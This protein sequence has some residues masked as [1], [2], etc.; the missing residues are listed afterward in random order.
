[1]ATASSGTASPAMRPFPPARRS[2][3]C[4]AIWSGTAP[5]RA[6]AGRGTAS[7]PACRRSYRRARRI[8]TIAIDRC[9]VVRR[10][11]RGDSAL[12]AD[13][14]R[15]LRHALLLEDLPHLLGRDGDVDVLHPEGREPVH[16]RIAL[17]RG[18]AH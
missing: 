10:E 6:T 1:M 9:T 4:S 15:L 5:V 16:H 11:E 3:R 17:G 2:T 18:R 7:P 12:L 14:E 13:D 8:G